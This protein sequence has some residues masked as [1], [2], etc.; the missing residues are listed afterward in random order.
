MRPPVL[1]RLL[2]G[3]AA[4]AL[5]FAWAAPAQA[6]AKAKVDFFVKSYTLAPGSSALIYTLLFADRPLPVASNAVSLKYELIN[7]PAAFTLQEAGH[8]NNCSVDIADLL[9]LTC[10]PMVDRLTPEGVDSGVVGYVQV[11]E[12]ATAGQTATL[13]ATMTVKGYAPVRRTAKIVV[14][15]GVTL[16]A[17][18]PEKER[19]AAPGATIDTPLT[20]TNSS[21]V[22]AQGTAIVASAQYAFQSRTQFSNCSYLEGVL[23]SCVFP[24]TLAPGVTYRVTLPMRVRQDTAAPSEQYAGWQW[25]TDEEFADFR[26]YVLKGGFGR[27][28]AAGKGGVLRLTEVTTA[29]AGPPQAVTGY[30][31]HGMKLTVTGEQSTDLAAVGVTARGKKGAVVTVP[32]GLRN[33]GPAALDRSRVNPGW[34]TVR[35]YVPNGATAVKVPELCAPMASSG[36]VDETR[37]G[38]PGE[39]RYSC[40]FYNLL[41][42]GGTLS[43]DFGL[44]MDKVVTGARG[45]VAV[46]AP[47]EELNKANNTAAVVINPPVAAPGGS[48]GSGGGGGLPITGPAAA[49]LVAVGLLLV[50]GGAGAFLLTRRRS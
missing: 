13:S 45:A 28:G 5:L 22:P 30:T 44:R 3:L 24:Q 33:N 10:G 14:G 49:G 7:Q 36:K 29:K 4:L 6:A 37:R 40:D 32:V 15:E 27:L 12:G 26:Q 19:S 11:A 42:V 38:E 9:E 31:S 35:F 2:A 34:P 46:G 17:V 20:I 50:L 8:P 41:K 16:T 18:D 21:T 39:L 48:G 43:F 1:R 47:A 25:M 23:T